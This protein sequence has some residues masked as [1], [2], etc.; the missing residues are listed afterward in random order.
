V[1]FI[2][3]CG[4]ASEPVASPRGQKVCDVSN[5][6]RDLP[7]L[8]VDVLSPHINAYETI[9]NILFWRR[10][11]HF[12]VLLV[13]VEFG[14]IYVSRCSL[15]VLSLASLAVAAFY[16]LRSC[17]RRPSREALPAN[18][19]RRPERI[20]SHLPAVSFLP[21]PFLALQS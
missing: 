6:A 20:E 19:Q 8:F 4:S 9:Q 2:C 15:G 16:V 1:I 13:I 3:I 5:R 7:Q 10:P 17:Q 11:L 21:A 12:G 14:F 18:E